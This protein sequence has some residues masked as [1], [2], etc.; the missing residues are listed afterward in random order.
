M[1]DGVAQKSVSANVFGAP[2]TSSGTLSAVRRS[3]LLLLVLSACAT[4]R[5]VVVAP[6]SKQE[7]SDVESPGT[8]LF[9]HLE[10]M[11]TGPVKV[12]LRVPRSLLPARPTA[13]TFEFIRL[14]DPWRVGFV[15][16]L[17]T[18]VMV[19]SA[20]D[21]EL[22]YEVS[23]ERLE[24]LPGETRMN[25]AFDLARGRHL[26]FWSL[27]PALRG[28]VRSEALHP[29]EVV[30]DTP[31]EFAT[32]LD[33]TGK[34]FFV[35]DVNA[36]YSGLLLVGSTRE[37]RAS[38]GLRLVSFDLDDAALARVATLERKVNATLEAQT[39]PRHPLHLL[40]LHRIPDG[41]RRNGAFGVN[42]QENAIALLSPGFDGAAMTADGLV[43]THEL[44]HS[45]LPG[46]G[47]LPHWIEEGFTEYFALRAALTIDGAPSEA[48]RELL[49]TAWTFFVQDSPNRRA[50]ATALGDYAG[51]LVLAHCIDVRLRRDGSSLEAVLKRAR[52]RAGGAWTNELWEQ[53]IA[54]AS[55]PAGALVVSARVDPLDPPSTCFAEEHFAR[56]PSVPALSPGAVG[57]WLGVSS[58]DR[59]TH[60]LGVLVSTVRAD[61]PFRPGDRLTRLGSR[62]LIGLEHLAELL[63]QN[64][65]STLRVE[66]SRDGETLTAELPA[67]TNTRTEPSLR[68]VWLP[69]P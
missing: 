52:E 27:V 63:A 44:T 38:G 5:A 14:P 32:S 16:G 45:S 12:Q 29:A 39:G 25:G 57:A 68:Q 19:S 26:P 3:C 23:V 49:S 59:S 53:E 20:E 54:V 42:V 55:A 30:I 34:R 48:L 10:V 60:Q 4:Q 2:T 31:F 51:G 1:S 8:R 17:P 46:S 66:F 61:S 9:V 56:R 69:V 33:G 22:D 37:V 65:A 62:R 28:A 43:V 21:L 47:N 58:V 50:G 36:L 18:T 41:L 24:R 35:D 11:A 67:P 7:M 40:A 6:V 64:S 13:L 15:R